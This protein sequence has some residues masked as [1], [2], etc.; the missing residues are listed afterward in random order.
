MEL[1][2]LHGV[3]PSRLS[4]LKKAGVCSIDDL[5][6]I[7]PVGYRDTTIITPVSQLKEKQPQIVI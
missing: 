4:A 1:S 7:F 3:G 2:E 6:S 5:L